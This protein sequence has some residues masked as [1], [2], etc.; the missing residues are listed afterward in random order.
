[1][2]LFDV[3]RLVWL[4]ALLCLAPAG[5]AIQG[6]DT[7]KDGGQERS[8]AEAVQP[9]ERLSTEE[10]AA[11]LIAA[12]DGEITEGQIASQRAWAPLVR[13]FAQR[14]IVEHSGSNNSVSALLSSIGSGPVE[15]PLSRAVAESGAQTA[16]A[17]QAVPAQTFDRAY[18]EGEIADHQ[19]ALTL[20]DQQLIPAADNEATLQLLTQARAMV[21]SHLELAQFV[22]QWVSTHS[23][24]R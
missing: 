20:I 6:A 24:Y 18:M 22:S 19:Q 4:T 5:C 7:D 17:L 16:A 12:N 1:M 3:H 11:V 14:M 2:R 8:A 23:V 13:A 10:I 15:S 21:A 9:V